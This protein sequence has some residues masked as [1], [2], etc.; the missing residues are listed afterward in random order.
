LDWV[1]DGG[2]TASIGGW[3][4][5]TLGGSASASADASAAEGGGGSGGSGGAG[6]G[7]ATGSVQN[8][9]MGSISG[10][11]YSTYDPE[12]RNTDFDPEPDYGEFVGFAWWQ[13]CEGGST[14]IASGTSYVYFGGDAEGSNG[15]SANAGYS[16]D[17][18][19]SQSSTSADVSLSASFP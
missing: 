1:A 17:S 14:V 5:P 11:A 7:W 10:N 13:C 3:A 4:Y 18:A 6:C 16:G 15:S 19:D 2:G 8:N 9:N 12:G